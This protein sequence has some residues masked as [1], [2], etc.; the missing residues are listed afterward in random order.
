MSVSGALNPPTS[1]DPPTATGLLDE[2]KQQ[3][4]T[5]AVFEDDFLPRF[6]ACMQ[7][8]WDQ[9]ATKNDSPF[10]TSSKNCRLFPLE[11]VQVIWK[12]V[13][14]QYALLLLLAQGTA[15]KGEEEVTK[16][17]SLLVDGVRGVGKTT[18]LQG[19]HNMMA[20]EFPTIIVSVYHDY[21]TDGQTLPSH[22][23]AAALE[24]DATDDMGLC[25]RQ[26]KKKKKLLFGFFDEIQQLYQESEES[27]HV[28]KSFDTSFGKKAVAQLLKMGKQIHHCGVV[29]AGSSRYARHFAYHEFLEELERKDV[30]NYA[31]LNHTVFTPRGLSPLRT[32]EEIAD[33][34]PDEPDAKTV[35]YATGGVP[36]DIARRH[37]DG[38]AKIAD[39]LKN[40]ITFEIVSLLV[41][42]NNLV[43]SKPWGASVNE[44]RIQELKDD[45]W[46]L[47]FLAIDRFKHM[48][49]YLFHLVRLCDSGILVQKEDKCE[50]GFARAIDAVEYAKH[51]VD[52]KQVQRSFAIAYTATFL[53]FDEGS[54][55]AVLELPT[56]ICAAQN[57][58]LPCTSETDFV[59]QDSL[60]QFSF[61][62]RS[63]HTRVKT[64][65]DLPKNELF[66]LAVD[67][68]SDG[69]WLQPEAGTLKVH[70]VQVKLGKIGSN[71]PVGGRAADDPS[72]TK[73][74]LRTVCARLKRAFED[75]QL[76]Q[77]DTPLVFGSM[78][79]LTSKTV[80]QSLV[81]KLHDAKT[82]AKG[83][84]IDGQARR[85]HVLQGGEN[86]SDFVKFVPSQYRKVLQSQPLV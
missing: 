47:N 74:T 57:N 2:F 40:D 66:R 51:V 28:D 85:L 71:I 61:S 76:H 50:Y 27:A 26:A 55:G 25:A 14:R 9:L 13:V 54:A 29:V 38:D 72:T 22:L 81:D 70:M 18:L 62:E 6:E 3:G 65:E 10:S 46:S 58:L 30:Y 52:P 86:C 39:H 59:G 68:G 60:K 34:F 32:M 56:L 49:R 20:A 84:Q 41:F 63:S 33:C 67:S 42:S 43:S 35:Y 36:R 21:E 16:N 80:K 37:L 4:M 44:G 64:T 69:W 77:G 1:M 53:G 7:Q 73:L 17:F 5:L 82:A 15:V 19:L 75:L 78:T 48:D 79:L 11:R 24:I 12:Q 31:N 23:F 83:L 8:T 45:P